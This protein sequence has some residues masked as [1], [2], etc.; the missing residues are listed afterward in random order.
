VDPAREDRPSSLNCRNEGEI[1]SFHIGGSNVALGDG[2]VRFLRNTIS[3]DVLVKL[4]TRWGRE[5]IDDAF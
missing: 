3:L 2:S 1:Y 4:C 5:S